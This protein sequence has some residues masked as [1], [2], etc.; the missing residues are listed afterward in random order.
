[1]FVYMCVCVCVFDYVCCCVIILRYCIIGSGFKGKCHV[2]TYS[3]Y[4]FQR[5]T[6][7]LGVYT[8]FSNIAF[9]AW[10]TKCLIVLNCC[11]C[12][13]M[14]TN[15]AGVDTYSRSSSRRNGT[16]GIRWNWDYVA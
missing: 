8:R 12:F 16:L 7:H 6:D 11:V 13:E 2:T 5:I 4:V 9:N 14:D 1:M 3:V 10:Y 15:T